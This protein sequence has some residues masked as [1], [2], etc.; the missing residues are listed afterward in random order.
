MAAGPAAA[1]AAV[2]GSAGKTSLG[3][4]VTMVNMTGVAVAVALAERVTLP[5]PMVRVSVVGIVTVS[6]PEMVRTSAAIIVAV[7]F[8]DIVMV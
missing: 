3:S 2:P 5:V 4:A 8:A 1:A 6:G 7:A